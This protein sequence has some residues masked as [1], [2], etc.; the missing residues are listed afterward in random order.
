MASFCHKWVCE[1]TIIA[2]L[3]ISMY[4]HYAIA[5]LSGYY[6]LCKSMCIIMSC[7]VQELQKA[8]NET[9]AFHEILPGLV[10]PSSNVLTGELVKNRYCVFCHQKVSSVAVVSK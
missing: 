9:V 1:S 6:A 4:C 7:K 3:Y 10:K 2:L 8:E 5:R